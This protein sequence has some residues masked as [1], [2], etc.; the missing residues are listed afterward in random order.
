MERG[1]NLSLLSP[2]EM[3][4]ANSALDGRVFDVLGSANAVA[5]FVSYGSTA[6][7]EVA[8]QIEYWKQKLA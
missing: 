3:L 2:E 1:C 4:A 7:A 5:A 8:K 6:P